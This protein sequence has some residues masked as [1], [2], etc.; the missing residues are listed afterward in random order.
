MD[1]NCVDKTKTY[2]NHNRTLKF[3]KTPEGLID[4]MSLCLRSDNSCSIKCVFIAQLNLCIPP[5]LGMGNDTM[6]RAILP[7]IHWCRDATSLTR[8]K[9]FCPM[10]DLQRLTRLH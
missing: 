2:R 8:Q 6:Y 7:L 4:N 1:H 10:T 9:Y 5:S 3:I